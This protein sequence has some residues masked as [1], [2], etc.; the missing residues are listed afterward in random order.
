MRS[1][2]PR[3]RR[4]PARR[5]TLRRHGL[6]RQ[7]FTTIR[8]E[9]GAILKSLPFI[10]ILL[11]AVLNTVGGAA[12][13]SPIF[14]TRFYPVTYEMLE[15]IEGNFFFFAVIIAAFYAGEIVWRERMLK[16]NEVT[17]AMP[18]PTWA[19]WAGKLTALCIT[20]Y[21]TLLAAVLTTIAV[22][23]LEA[24]P[25]LRARPLLPR[26][27]PRS[28]A[29]KLLLVDDPD[30]LRPDPH[31]QPLRRIS[32]RALLHHRAGR[33]GRAALRAPPLPVFVAARHDVLGHERLRPLRAAVRVVQRSTGRSSRRSC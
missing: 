13:A 22:Q 1:L 6:V 28:S 18:S 25:P 20:L 23:A 21:I 3:R 30:V 12:F 16:L 17:D 29:S 9:T 5:A 11:L 33:A 10:V 8:V 27:V 2:V 14:G 32:D 19:I 4:D 24:L 26:R 7:Y 31:Q 15:V